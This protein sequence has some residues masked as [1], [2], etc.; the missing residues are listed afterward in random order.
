[1][2]YSICFNH[3]AHGSANIKHVLVL[4]FQPSSQE[5]AF[6]VWHD[7]DSHELGEDGTLLSCK[8]HW[9]SELI[10]GC[11]LKVLKADCCRE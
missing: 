5:L 9:W 1:M 11:V 8:L 4:S 10:L 6:V 2:H 3:P 7:K